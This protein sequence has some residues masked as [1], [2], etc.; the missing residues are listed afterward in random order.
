MARFIAPADVGGVTL[1]AGQFEV[2]DGHIETPDDLGPGDIV[3]LAAN[4]FAPVPPEKPARGGKAK[5]EPA[6]EPA[7]EE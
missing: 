6:T 4:G 3:G 2:V 1:T 7:A 5:A